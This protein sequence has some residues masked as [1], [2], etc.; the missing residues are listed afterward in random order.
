MFYARSETIAASIPYVLLV[1][2]I[3]HGRGMLD[4]I[5]RLTLQHSCHTSACLTRL[6]SNIK[7]EMISRHMAILK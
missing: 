4:A 7:L 1:D 5:S 2:I 6:E 3:W